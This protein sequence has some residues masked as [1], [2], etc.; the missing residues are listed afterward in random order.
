LEPTV[1]F[2]KM[3]AEPP[4]ADVYRLIPWEDEKGTTLRQALAA[5]Q[6]NKVELLIGPEGGFSADEVKQASE[7]GFTAVTLGARILRMETAAM[8]AT[9]LVLYEGGEMD[10]ISGQAA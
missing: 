8:A 4:V 6:G 1:K 7:A 3:L 2:A 5:H 9:A 10:S